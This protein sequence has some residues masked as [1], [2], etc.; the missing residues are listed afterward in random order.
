MHGTGGPCLP[1]QIQRT[2]IGRWLSRQFAL[3]AWSSAAEHC[4]SALWPNVL[5]VVRKSRNAGGLLMRPAFSSNG[6]R[7]MPF[8]SSENVHFNHSAV[9]VPFQ[10]SLSGG[11]ALLLRCLR[12]LGSPAWAIWV[13]VAAYM[14]LIHLL[15]R[16]QSC[17]SN[18]PLRPLAY[19]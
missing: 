17:F 10:Y 2:P 9:I 12:V 5:S 15:A 13:T 14:E 6:A 8:D 11:Y 18:L 19:P 4:G 16:A 1:I 7:P 3:G